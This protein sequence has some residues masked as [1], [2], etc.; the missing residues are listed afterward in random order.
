M[1]AE[2]AYHQILV[3]LTATRKAYPTNAAGYASLLV[4]TQTTHHRQVN[5]Y[6][7]EGLTLRHL[8]NRGTER[9]TTDIQP[10]PSP[11][12]TCTTTIPLL[13]SRCTSN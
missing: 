2:N 1:S 6:N 9:C 3:V 11:L 13:I 10:Y 12:S 5:T 8:W 7:W 4:I